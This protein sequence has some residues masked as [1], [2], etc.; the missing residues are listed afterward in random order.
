VGGEGQGGHSVAVFRPVNGAGRFRVLRCAP[1]LRLTLVEAVGGALLPGPV[2]E[3][4]ALPDAVAQ[5]RDGAKISL[6]VHF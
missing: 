4:A 5:F 6:F 2:P 1:G 3:V